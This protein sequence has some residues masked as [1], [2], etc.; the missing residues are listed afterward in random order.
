LVEL[1]VNRLNLDSWIQSSKLIVLLIACLIGLI[2]ESGPHLIFVTLYVSGTIPLSILL[3]SS[4]VQDGHGALPLL[5]HSRK[6][7]LLVKLINFIAGISVGGILLLNG[8]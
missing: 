8:L 6:I 3:A 4:I 1:I 5:A 7:F 2:P